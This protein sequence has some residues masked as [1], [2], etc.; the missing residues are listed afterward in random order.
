[1]AIRSKRRTNY[2]DASEVKIQV[3]H[4]VPHSHYDEVELWYIKKGYARGLS[5]D[6]FYDIN[7]GDF[8]ISFPTQVH[9]YDNIPVGETEILFCA[10][11]VDNLGPLSNVFF[12][13]VPTTPLYHCDDESLV[14]LLRFIIAEQKKNLDKLYINSLLTAFFSNL[15][16]H[17]SLAESSGES[18]TVSEVIT[19]CQQNFK[20]ELS[21]NKIAES[22]YLS[23]SYISYIFSKKLQIPFNEYINRL[24]AD[25]FTRL[26]LTGKYS[27]VQA[28]IEAGFTS[29]RTLNRT[30]IKMYN[31]SPMQFIKRNKKTEQQ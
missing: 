25:E 3:S 1:M 28:M 26:M 31:M 24:R 19:F 27:L 30:F 5:E 14:D 9:D 16:S 7:E 6:K 20:E 17:Y 13:K 18:T 11:T 22:L 4:Y 23:R 8:F 29:Q 21:L 2:L 15:L 10:T 12:K